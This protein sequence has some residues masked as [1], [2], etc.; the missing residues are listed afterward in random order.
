M[1]DRY[2]KNNTTEQVE[3]LSRAYR[4]REYIMMKEEQLETLRE[5]A[6][7]VSASEL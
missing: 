5:A 1:G 4:L 3:F 2:G 6:E 7:S